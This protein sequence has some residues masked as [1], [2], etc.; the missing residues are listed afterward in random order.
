MGKLDGDV[1]AQVV[2]DTRLDPTGTPVLAVSGELDMSNAGSL[3]AA[4]AAIT[5]QHPARL[6]FD[7]SGVRF[8]DSAG[9]AVL[10]GAA[11]DVSAVVLRDPS[12]VVRRVI[13]LTGLAGVLPIES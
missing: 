12:P 1:A 7:L 10:V 9:I 8:M 6:I 2:V 13:D 3:E 11:T 5:A 4:V